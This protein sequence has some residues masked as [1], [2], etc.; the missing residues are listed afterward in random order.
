VGTKKPVAT[1]YT[2]PQPILLQ[3]TRTLTCCY[4]KVTAKQGQFKSAKSLYDIVLSGWMGEVPR[5]IRKLVNPPPDNR[6]LPAHKNII[7]LIVLYK[8]DTWS[9]FL[10]EENIFKAWR[11]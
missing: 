7:L 10:R 9:V 5:L 11:T 6:Q 2:Y 1:A 3:H 8:P 4:H